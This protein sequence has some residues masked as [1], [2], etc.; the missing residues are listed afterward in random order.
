VFKFIFQGRMS[1][2]EEIGGRVPTGLNT[3]QGEM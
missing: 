2:W 1:S 3:F